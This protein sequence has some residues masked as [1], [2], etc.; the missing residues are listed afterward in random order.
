MVQPFASL[1]NFPDRGTPRLLINRERVGPFTFGSA[2]AF[3]VQGAAAP[4]QPITDV[5][6]QG[7]CDAGVRELARLAGMGDELEALCV[8]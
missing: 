7:D 3:G 6:Y 1:A 5:W 2:E 8:G 4:A